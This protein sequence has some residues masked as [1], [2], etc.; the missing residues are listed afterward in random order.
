M[1]Q[2]VLIC[3]S[4][5]NDIYDFIKEYV[6]EDTWYIDPYGSSKHKNF[7]K[8]FAND[9]KILKI[10]PNGTIDRIISV[11]CWY[12]IYFERKKNTSIPSYPFK[13]DDNLFNNLH[14]LLK[15]GGI[16]KLGSWYLGAYNLFGGNDVD[17]FKSEKDQPYDVKINGVKYVKYINPELK[18]LMD[19]RFLFYKKYNYNPLI[20]LKF[21]IYWTDQIFKPYKNKFKIIKYGYM[22]HKNTNKPIEFIPDYNSY[23]ENDLYTTALTL[24]KI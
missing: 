3:H 19:N 20:N 18:Q 7:I 17:L 14:K 11:H 22:F 12:M 24:K 1:S 16:V 6:N 4:P 15:K 23:E 5:E 8:L 21:M 10:I 2:T 9:K 13:L